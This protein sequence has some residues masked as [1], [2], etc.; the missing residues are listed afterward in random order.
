MADSKVAPPPAREPLSPIYPI[1]LIEVACRA[2]DAISG[3]K[4]GAVTLNGP[5]SDALGDAT[6]SAVRIIRD[7]LLSHEAAAKEGRSRG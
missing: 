1:A 6:A 5:A 2:L 3:L 7:G 4:G